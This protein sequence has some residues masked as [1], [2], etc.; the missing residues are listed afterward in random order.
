MRNRKEYLVPMVSLVKIE[1]EAPLTTFSPNGTIEGPVGAKRYDEDYL[2]W[3]IMEDL[4]EEHT[5]KVSSI[6]DNDIENE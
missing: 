4:K 2:E 3:E 1:T 5:F 6:W